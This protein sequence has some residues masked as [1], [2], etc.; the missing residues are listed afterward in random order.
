MAS[1][2][3]AEGPMEGGEEVWYDMSLHG[4]ELVYSGVGQ[5]VHKHLRQLELCDRP[6]GVEIRGQGLLCVVFMT[7]L[8]A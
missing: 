8:P 3:R 5:V 4:E 6:E 1:R 7:S 2:V